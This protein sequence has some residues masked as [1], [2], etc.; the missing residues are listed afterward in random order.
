MIWS[1]LPRD[2]PPRTLRQFA[3]L[4]LLVFLGMGWHRNWLPP[5]S[6]L[7][8]GATALVLGAGLLGLI[9]PRAVRP[10]FVGWLMLTFPIGWLV[11]RLVLLLLYYG[12][13]APLGLWFQLIGRDALGLRR[14]PERQTCWAPKPAAPSLASYYRQY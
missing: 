9:R 8:C 2:P 1:E 3:A 10:I 13:F 11:S 6:P 5:S 14:R 12:L 7:G 4:C